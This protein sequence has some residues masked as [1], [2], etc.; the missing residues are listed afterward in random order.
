M[1]AVGWRLPKGDVKFERPDQSR[2]K[3]KQDVRVI[4]ALIAGG[5]VY[6]NACRPEEKPLDL[7]A[8]RVRTL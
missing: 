6:T 3:S 5:M 1:N 8:Y 7:S 2:A 4:D